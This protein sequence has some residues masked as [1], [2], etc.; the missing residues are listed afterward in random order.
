MASVLNF[1]NP[2]KV[3]GKI[4]TKFNA[5][6]SLHSSP[7]NGVD[8][9][10]NCE[11]LYAPADGVITRFWNDQ[12]GL[13]VRILHANGYTTGYAHLLYAKFCTGTTIKKGEFFAIT[14]NSG[15][16]TGPHLHFTLT[17]PKGV[18]IDPL[19]HFSF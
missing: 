14:G 5:I 13:Q 9:V 11:D 2:L 19:L 1:S 4:S 7:H 3:P 15:H 6:D 12:G 18:K 16:S 10:V 8:V 17:N